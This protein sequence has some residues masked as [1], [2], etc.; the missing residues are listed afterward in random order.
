MVLL[1]YSALRLLF[2]SATPA[3]EVHSP[4]A[5]AILIAV[6]AVNVTIALQRHS[7]WLMGLALTMGSAI[8][9]AAGTASLILFTTAAV[10]LTSVTVSRR[11]RWPGL[12]LVGLVLTHA[13]YFAWAMGNPFRTGAVRFVHDP[14]WAPVMLLALMML[15]GVAPLLRGREGDDA[16]TNLASFVNC[17]LGYGALLVH[18]AAV[19]PT[20]FAAFHIVGAVALIGLAM[21]FFVRAQSRVSTFFYAMTGY[22]ALSLAILKLSRAPEVFI[23]LSAQSVIVVATAIWF[24][25]RFIVVAN[26]F[27]FAAIVTTYIGV[28]RQESGISVVFGLVALATARILNWKQHRLE[29]KT[30]LM[31]NAYL[32]SAFVI[33]PYAGYHLVPV[34]YVALVWIGLAAAYYVLNVVVKN[35]KYRWMGHGTLMLT[36]VYVIGAGVSRFEPVYRVLS[37]LVLGFALLTVSLLFARARRRET[38]SKP[39]DVGS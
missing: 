14:E 13:T 24:R 22:A 6:T 31:R 39:V 5:A 36:T 23:W 2:F 4:L 3:L 33:F 8:A 7:P 9:L 29:L 19:F 1:G 21:T 12:L 15:L 17:A 11:E 38:A 27:I 20:R 37:F 34:K 32:V 10:A 18:T 16:P 25:S 28:T 35:Q 26:F 30:D